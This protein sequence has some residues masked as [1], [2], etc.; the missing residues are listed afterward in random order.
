MSP[1]FNATEGFESRVAD[2]FARQA[3][4]TSIGATLEKVEAGRVVIDL[5]FN[6]AF[7]QQHGYMNAGILSTVIDTACGYAAFSLMPA[8]AAVLTVEFKVNLLRPAEGERFR[9]IGVVKKAGRTL[10]VTEGELYSDTQRL[11]ATMSATMMTIVDRP[12]MDG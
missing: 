11:I 6:A 5:P 1:T 4:M 9:A 8:D 2:S 12:G 7:T 10:S 3:A